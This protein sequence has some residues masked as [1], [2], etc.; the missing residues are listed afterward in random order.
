ML[1]FVVLI[2]I[3]GYFGYRYMHSKAL[4]NTGRVIDS[5][6]ALDKTPGFVFSTTTS[7]TQCTTTVCSSTDSSQC[8]PLSGTVAADKS[9]SLDAKQSTPE[10]QGLLD[11]INANK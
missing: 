5:T 9:C 1:L 6:S 2:I 10:S 8:I 4:D 3:L 11:I 7:G